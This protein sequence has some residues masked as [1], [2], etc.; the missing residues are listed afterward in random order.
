MSTASSPHGEYTPPTTAAGATPPA[1]PDDARRLSIHKIEVLGHMNSQQ[2]DLLQEAL[3][4]ALAEVGYHEVW[5]ML[6]E[7]CEVSILLEER[8]RALREMAS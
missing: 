8:G 3:E 5:R 1:L 4:A 6:H 2:A 7:C